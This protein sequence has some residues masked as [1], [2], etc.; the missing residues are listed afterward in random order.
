MENRTIEQIKPAERK[1]LK[2]KLIRLKESYRKQNKLYHELFI[3][4]NENIIKAIDR[5]LVTGYRYKDEQ[6]SSRHLKKI[7]DSSQK[8]KQKVNVLLKGKQLN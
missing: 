3:L 6:I 4:P 1:E 5:F 2:E 7:M 8:Y